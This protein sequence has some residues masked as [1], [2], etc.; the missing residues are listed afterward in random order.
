MLGN[1]TNRNAV[2]ALAVTLFGT[3]GRVDVRNN[4]FDIVLV[5]NGLVPALLAADVATPGDMPAF[6]ARMKD[7]TARR[8]ADALTLMAS[9]LWSAWAE[10]GAPVLTGFSSSCTKELPVGDPVLR[11]FPVPGGFTHPDGGTGEAPVDA[12]VDDAGAGGSGGSPV[13][14]GG[15][16]GGMSLVEPEPIAC[17]CGGVEGAMLLGL[18]VMRLGRR[19]R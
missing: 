13:V 16:A 8:W 10:A 9:V 11:G 6:F 5:G 15:G 4:I 2:A 14:G 3:P 17:S 12:G 19:R 7:S 18:L 1:N